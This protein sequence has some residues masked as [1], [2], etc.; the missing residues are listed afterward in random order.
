[1]AYAKRRQP[2]ACMEVDMALEEGDLVPLAGV[3]LVLPTNVK[4]FFLS[5]NF[6]KNASLFSVRWDTR[7]LQVFIKY[8]QTNPFF[9][10]SL[11]IFLAK[12]KQIILCLWIEGKAI[13]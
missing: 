10:I 9:E 11:V 13:L 8:F 6:S 7:L 2:P 1:M 5:L 3:F 4:H 12:T